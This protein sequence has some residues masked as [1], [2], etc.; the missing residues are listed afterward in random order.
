MSTA[1]PRRKTSLTLRQR[2]HD[3]VTAQARTRKI[4]LGEALDILA[5]EHKRLFELR[6]DRTEV[7]ADRGDGEGE[8]EWWWTVLPAGPHS[9][10]LVLVTDG[11]GE[12]SDSS[13]FHRCHVRDG[14][15][16]TVREMEEGSE[17]Y[18][19]A[20]ATRD[21]VARWRALRVL[22]GLHAGREAEGA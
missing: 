18:A 19:A 10:M 1:E 20:A 6:L 13:Y 11:D 5:D 17:Y 9:R 3:Y 8:V 2:T 22:D 16:D 14:F 15:T 12:V 4:S 21:F 7:I